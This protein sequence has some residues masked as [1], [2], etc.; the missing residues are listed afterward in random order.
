MADEVLI[1]RDGGIATIIL[2]RP[3]RLNAL[4]WAMWQGVS[5][6]MA[7]L[8]REDDIRCIVLRRREGVRPRRRHRRIRRAALER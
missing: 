6:A 3:D 2:N 5:D 1:E 8:D 4:T 7:A